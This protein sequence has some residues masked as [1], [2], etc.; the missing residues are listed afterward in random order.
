MGKSQF[1]RNIICQDIHFGAGVVVM[2]H[3]RDLFERIMDYYPSHRMYDLIYYNQGDR[4]NT[5]IGFNLFELLP[6]EDPA[7]KAGEIYTVLERTLDDLGQTMKPILQ[8]AI[9]ALVYM[10]QGKTLRD[11]ERLI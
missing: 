7:F 8:S 4:T 11:L 6:H 5:I 9:D 3:E 1:L 10:Q 2:G